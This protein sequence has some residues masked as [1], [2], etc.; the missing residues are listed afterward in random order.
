M[1]SKKDEKIEFL[2]RLFEMSHFELDMMDPF[3]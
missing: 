3:D 1:I 2:D